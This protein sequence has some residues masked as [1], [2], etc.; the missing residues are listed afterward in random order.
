MSHFALSDVQ[1][2]H[3]NWER[4]SKGN[5]MTGLEVVA[6]HPEYGRVGEM[7]LPPEPNDQ[8]SREILDMGVLFKRQGVGKGLYEY[9]KNA[10]LNPA[11][12]SWRT[13]EGDAFAR[14]VGGH[15][16]EWKKGQA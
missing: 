1:F 11:H 10:G 15:L 5:T 3:E 13:P 9:A 8:G 4:T 16:P 12:S 14:S 7:Q 6:E 2:R